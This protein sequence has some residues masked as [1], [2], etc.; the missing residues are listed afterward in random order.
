MVSG[1]VEVVM[2]DHGRAFPAQWSV[3]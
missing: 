3:T 2:R 1:E